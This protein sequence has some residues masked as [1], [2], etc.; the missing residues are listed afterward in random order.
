MEHN[1]DTIAAIN[2][3]RAIRIKVN[4]A[5]EHPHPLPLMTPKCWAGYALTGL[6]CLSEILLI[7][8]L[9]LRQSLVTHSLEWQTRRAGAHFTPPSPYTI[10]RL[11]QG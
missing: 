4:V 5:F 7:T 10:Y 11:S 3:P 1:H 6:S 9:I 2:H 8:V